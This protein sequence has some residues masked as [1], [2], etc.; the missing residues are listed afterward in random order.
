MRND[1]NGLADGKLEAYFLAGLKTAPL[2]MDQLRIALPEVIRRGELL[3]L[4]AERGEGAEPSELLYPYG[5]WSRGAISQLWEIRRDMKLGVGTIRRSIGGRRALEAIERARA[6]SGRPRGA[7]T[8]LLVGHSGGGI[9]A[10]HAAELLLERGQAESCFVVKIGSPRCRIPE[11]L[12]PRVLAIRAERPEAGKGG[13]GRPPDIVPS[14]G[15]YGG[16]SRER[17]LPGWRR[18]LHAPGTSVGLSIVGK[19]AD[20]FRDRE[21]FL[22]GE[23]RTNLELVV[24]T[25]LGWLETIK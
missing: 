11:R 12:K 24:D 9:A 1:S 25:I 20:Y 23:G 3:G 17:R 19:H 4:S 13:A 7:R 15:S 8:T 6:A 10:V 5:D 18:D 14:F 2:F 16:W 21:P 22:N